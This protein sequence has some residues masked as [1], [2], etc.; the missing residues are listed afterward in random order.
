MLQRGSWKWYLDSLVSSL[1]WVA[2]LSRCGNEKFQKVNWE[3]CYETPSEY[4][5]LNKWDLTWSKGYYIKNVVW[6][7]WRNYLTLPYAQSTCLWMRRWRKKY[8]GQYK[9]TGRKFHVCSHFIVIVF[10]FVFA[11]TKTRAERNAG[12][13][14]FE[15]QSGKKTSF[16]SQSNPS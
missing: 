9:I 3:R 11:G 14:E 12:A 6:T 10:F 13:G 15:R 5:Q 16:A 2:L 1:I 4:C 8:C 7:L